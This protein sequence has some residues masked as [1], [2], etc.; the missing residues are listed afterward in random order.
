MNR[1]R[2]AIIGLGWLGMPLAEQLAANG[3]Q[4]KGTKRQAA[5]HSAIEIFPFELSHFAD[6]KLAPLFDVD[7]MVINIPPSKIA[8]EVYLAGCKGLVERGILQKVKQVIFVSTTGVYPQSTGH[9]DE[10]SATDQSNLTAQ[11]EQ[12]LLALPIQ[13]D[14]LRLAGLVG[15]NRHPVRYL[16]GK[17]D[18]KNADQ[19]VNLVH[20]TDCIRAIELLLNKP[21]GSRIFNLVAPLHP[22]RQAYYSEMAQKFELPDLQFSAD[23]APVVRVISGEKICNTLGFEYRYPDPFEMV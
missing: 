1:K 15:C 7:A 12:Q 4:V 13:V 14:I 16:A 18:L 23:N 5:E 9:F 10:R 17:K 20:Q 21:N 11:L 3:W 2:V 8:P 6:E 19:P 22:T